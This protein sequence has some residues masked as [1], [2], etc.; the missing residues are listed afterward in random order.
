M[1]PHDCLSLHVDA[2][3]H[4]D[5]SGSGTPG[6][7]QCG[8]GTSFPESPDLN[9]VGIKLQHNAQPYRASSAN[10]VCTPEPAFYKDAFTS[11]FGNTLSGRLLMNSLKTLV[12][13]YVN[14]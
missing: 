14:V 2:G 3:I 10:Y 13:S 12:C 7:R 4:V 6:E 9:H 5:A 8:D 11:A 1:N